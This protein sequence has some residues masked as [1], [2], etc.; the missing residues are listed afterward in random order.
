MRYYLYIFWLLLLTSAGAA[1]AQQ[2]VITGTI[3][4]ADGPL[5][6][7]S[8]FEKGMSNNGTTAND[9][10][11]FTLT[12]RGAGNI[13]VVQT[14]GYLAREVN[15][16]GKTTIIIQLEKA[17]KAMEEVVVAYSKQK[18]VTLTGAVSSVTGQDIRQ[19][20]S[21]SLQNTLSGRLPGFFS[22]QRSGQ[23][24]LDGAAFNIRGVSTLAAGNTNPL[25]LVDDIEFTY[26]QFAR[27]DPNEVENVTILKDASTTAVYGIKGANGVVLVT[28]RRGRIGKPQI[29]LRSEVSAQ[30]P[31]RIPEY[32]DAYETAKLFNQ[33]RI[34]D[35]MT[36]Y[37]TDDDLQKYKDGSDP[38]GHPNNNWK[39]ILFS[40]YSAQWR[41]NLDISGGTERVKYFVSVGYLWQ[42]GML[43][44]F[45]KDDEVNSGFYY[46]R[47]NYRSNLDVKVT[48]TTDLRLDLYGNVGER[49]SPYFRSANGINDVFWEYGSFLT[50]SPYAYPIYNPNGSY[51]YSTKQ[52]DRYNIGNII[53]RLSQ[54]GY[55]RN[56]ENNMNLNA[57]LNQKL[58][59]ITQGLSVRGTVAY[60]STYSYNRDNNRQTNDYPQFIYNPDTKVYT[61][62]DANLYRVRRYF[63]VY[64]A[65]NTGRTVNLQGILNYNRTFGDHHFYGLALV[66][67]NTVIKFENNALYNYIPS[68]F[69]G[70]SGRI[71]YDF[72]QKYLVEFNAGYNGSERFIGSKRYGFFPAASAGWNISEEGFFRNNIKFIDRFKI[73]GSYGLVGSDQLPNGM[74]YSY[75]QFYNS[76]GGTSFGTAD[77]GQTI[78]TEGTLANAEVTWEKEKKLNIGVDL[79]LFNNKLTITA[80]YF[81]H[82]RYDILTTRGT[83]SAI[84]GQTLPPVNLAKVNNHG[85]E[86]DISYKDNIGKD[87]DYWVKANYSFARN[88][89]VYQD[90]PQASYPWMQ[91]T[92]KSVGMIMVYRW[93]G[94]YESE[95][96][97]DK[98]PTFGSRPKVGDL[99]YADINGDGKLDGYD[100]EY[101]GYPNLPNTNVGFSFGANYKNF[102]F[103]MLFQGAYNF[104]VRGVA[105]A[106]QAFG[107]NMQPLHQ[108][109]WTPE[110]GNSARYPRLSL[111][112]GTNE[113]RAYPSTFWFIPGD[114]LRLRNAEIG[115]ALPAKWTKKIG[116]TN[117]RVYIN[118]YNLFSWSRI[119]D[120]YQFD[121]EIN[122][123]NDRS[124]YPPQRILNLGITATF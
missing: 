65:G 69:R 60:A 28:T 63:L 107:S 44:N 111:Q 1:R 66:N 86:F 91:A 83:V 38:Y 87:F 32:L 36:P 30:Q 110:R 23:P 93:T 22:Q 21:A 76:A 75:E 62:K 9:Q 112:A 59:F 78:V 45:G 108:E 90:E 84:F 97:I 56:F 4:D 26:D 71:G 73:R 11:Q 120:R 24:G 61:P 101:A 48:G 102:S 52:P 77:N 85:Y 88:K 92:G 72:R 55:E 3:K 58:D 54:G 94:F 100:Q 82:N 43:K 79:A 18:K 116:I 27:L 98:S 6:G 34:N 119:Q 41:N 40:D 114:Y 14:V 25:I 16:A 15:I 81:D 53:A 7:A 113:P 106:I 103:S 124:N 70:Y 2:K 13:L 57:T 115:Y 42:N 109:Y 39:D 20:P 17:D 47:Y 64:S 121:P 118:G 96:D 33:A 51:G 50:L 37:F 29:A 12:L 67:Q 80:D 68:N 122:S 105:E 5:P 89:I 123:G 31:T 8:V 35:G 117:S 10:G 95:E 104:H 99:K 46:K 74:K 19:N 49:N